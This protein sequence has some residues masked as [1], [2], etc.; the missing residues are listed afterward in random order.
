MAKIE[1]RWPAPSFGSNELIQISP[2][3]QPK[4]NLEEQ[5]QSA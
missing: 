5:S 3:K 2:F 4:S 1:E